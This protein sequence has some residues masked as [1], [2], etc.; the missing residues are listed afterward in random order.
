MKNSLIFLRSFGDFAMALSILRRS[1]VA[2]DWIFYASVHLEPLYK[3]LLPFLP[4]LSL[5]IRF[6]DIGIK[7][8]VF[9]YFTNRHSIEWYSM[10]ELLNLKKV[11]RSLEGNIHF[12]QRRKQ[13]FVAPVLGKIY[14]YV[15]D[16]RQNI[17]QSFCE[18]FDVPYRSLLFTDGAHLPQNILILPESRK[19]SKAIPKNVIESYASAYR[20]KGA[21]VITAFFR[22]PGLV[23]YHNFTELIE[24]IRSADMVITADSLPAHLAQLLGKPHQI[25]YKGS[26]NE[27]WITPYAKGLANALMD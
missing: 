11:L 4:A 15:H 2:K 27:E 17:Y 5:D 22:Q 19:A 9:G 7:K 1:A 6:I 16:N 13:W 21:E 8:N 25:Y 23:S 26:V 3:E 24:L 20:E 18:V 14:P 10:I 12:E